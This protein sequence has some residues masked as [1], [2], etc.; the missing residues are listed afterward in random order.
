[1][2]SIIDLNKQVFEKQQYQQVVNTSFTELTV[3]NTTTTS[4]EVT[5]LLSVQEFF[6]NYSQLFYTIP[7][8]G[9]TNSTSYTE[10]QN[11]KIS[12]RSCDFCCQSREM[13]CCRPF[14]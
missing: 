1:M 7:K 8:T 5:P 14:L 10:T 13:A 11:S 6:D 3:G 2:S 9:E 4:T 12:A